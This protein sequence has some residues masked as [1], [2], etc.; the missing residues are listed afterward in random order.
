MLHQYGVESAA[1]EPGMGLD[2]FHIVQEE[3]PVDADVGEI[4]REVEVSDDPWMMLA[5]DQESEEEQ[6]SE[7]GREQ[8]WV[9]RCSICGRYARVPHA[10][11][12]FCKS[13]PSWHH[14]RCCP[15]RPR[16]NRYIAWLRRRVPWMSVQT[17]I[18]I[19]RA[20]LVACFAA[21]IVVLQ[22]ILWGTETS[23]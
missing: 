15:Q 9:Q 3:E 4:A 7:V 1:D 18:M 10:Y 17:R 11:C 19:L 20:A 5:E 8:A 21:V 12:K 13:R 6:N 22:N 16:W 14:G 23:S 2:P